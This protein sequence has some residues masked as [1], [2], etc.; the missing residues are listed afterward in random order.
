MH[1]ICAIKEDKTLSPTSRAHFLSIGRQALRETG[2]GGIVHRGCVASWLTCY[3]KIRERPSPDAIT[4][5][6]LL[7]EL[8]RSARTLRLLGTLNR[9][10]G[11][12]FAGRSPRDPFIAPRQPTETAADEESDDQEP[13]V[14]DDDG[15]VA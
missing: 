12:R 13:E 5:G 2:G 14:E 4:T 6:R 15:E 7:A 3:R 10:E 11:S 1:W 8:V 9:T